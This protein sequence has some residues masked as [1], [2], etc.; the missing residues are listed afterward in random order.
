MPQKAIAKSAETRARILE[1]A[2]RTFRERGFE[3]A[4]MR[5]IAAAAGMAT[6]AAYYYFESKEAIVMAFYQRAQEEMGPGVEESLARSRTLEARVRGI[7]TAKLEYFL[8]NRPLMSAL[9]AHVDPTHPLSPFSEQTQPIRE[10]DLAHFE[11]AVGES[12][13]RLPKNIAPYLPRLLWLYQ[14]GV[15]LFWVYDR[16]RDQ[17]RTAVLLEKTLKMIVIGVRMAGLP[18][19]RP[20]HRLAGELLETLYGKA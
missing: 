10:H 15:L 17:Q 20:V 13:L 16:S 7:I 6:G 14:M 3:G 12:Q 1:A 2:L 5:E 19:L 4:T 18:F 11:R 9:T 8:P